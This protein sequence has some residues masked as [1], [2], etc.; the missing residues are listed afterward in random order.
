[1][2]EKIVWC[3][4]ALEHLKAVANHISATSETAG[5]Q[6]VARI[7]DA[8]R[9]RDSYPEMG[10]V[11]PEFADGEVREILVERWRV[12]YWIRSIRI[13]VIDILESRKCWRG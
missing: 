8:V 5:D 9:W 7:L 11:R 2:A 12:I 6:A 1:M 3:L 10:T 13:D 4:Q